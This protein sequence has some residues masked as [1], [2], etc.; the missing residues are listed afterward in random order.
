MPISYGRAEK[1]L[2]AAG[3]RS[4]S[5]RKLQRWAEPV[6]EISGPDGT[7]QPVGLLSGGQRKG[8]GQGRGVDWTLSD[9][10]LLTATFIQYAFDQMEKGR[11]GGRTLGDAGLWA[12]LWGAPVPLPVVRHH[13]GQSSERIE[14]RV[15]ERL[16]SRRASRED[17]VLDLVD[18]LARHMAYDD[19]VL[20]K[21]GV[22]VEDRTRLGQEALSAWVGNRW[23]LSD[24]SAEFY[25]R[26]S[27]DYL[28][29]ITQLLA[30]LKTATTEQ[31]FEALT[32]SGVERGLEFYSFKN[33]RDIYSKCPDQWLR[34]I[35]TTFSEGQRFLDAV[36]DAI[37]SKRPVLPETMEQAKAI[38]A[39]YNMLGHLTPEAV[40]SL[41]LWRY[42]TKATD[43]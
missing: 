5:K 14:K 12:F 35:Q 20:K 36:S 4:F 34:E 16:R 41:L 10:D 27:G 17:D 23:G 31:F 38:R 13:L 28:Q 32:P 2:R 37:R 40:I 33:L 1:A 21:V 6:V 18:R 19:A 30:G 3:L 43:S 7:A 11:L 29:K 42:T 25:N 15:E 39:L 26:F 9:D 22:P 24:E 8:Q